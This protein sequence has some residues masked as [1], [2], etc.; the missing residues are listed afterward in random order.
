MGTQKLQSCRGDHDVTDSNQGEQ[1]GYQDPQDTEHCDHRLHFNVVVQGVE[2]CVNLFQREEGN[3]RCVL[4]VPLNDCRRILVSGH[5]DVVLRHRPI[6]QPRENLAIAIGG[7]RSESSALHLAADEGGDVG[8]ADLLEA[9]G[10]DDGHFSPTV[11]AG[12]GRPLFGL[13]RNLSAGDFEGFTDRAEG[14][15]QIVNV[16]LGTLGRLHVADVRDVGGENSVNRRAGCEWKVISPRLGRFKLPQFL[17][18]N[19]QGFGSGGDAFR[20]TGDHVLNVEGSVT[21]NETR[22]GGTPFGMKSKGLGESAFILAD[23]GRIS[24]QN[25]L[26]TDLGNYIFD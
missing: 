19:L 25:L 13:C 21:K 3:F 23:I 17:F 24:A 16:R 18:G 5:S 20:L 14:V 15:P 6:E 11:L 7:F 22:H 4:L 2:L 9:I 10:F 1:E 8:R 12:L 26:C